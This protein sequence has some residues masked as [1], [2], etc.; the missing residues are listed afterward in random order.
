MK[1]VNTKQLCITG[2]LWWGAEIYVYWYVAVHAY[3]ASHIRGLVLAKEKTSA[4]ACCRAGLTFRAFRCAL[5]AR[6]GHLRA[7]EEIQS[8]PVPEFQLVPMV[9]QTLAVRQ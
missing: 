3:T 6:G 7:H 8:R 1:L 9:E 5:R 4:P 2:S